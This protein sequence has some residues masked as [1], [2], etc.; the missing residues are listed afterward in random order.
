MFV[1]PRQKTWKDTVN[2][3]EV[4]KCVAEADKKGMMM[5]Y[6]L[7]KLWKLAIDGNYSMKRKVRTSEAWIVRK[8]GRNE[9]TPLDAC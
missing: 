1:G 2:K 6:M 5:K 3:L 7:P 4:M 9:H 8:E